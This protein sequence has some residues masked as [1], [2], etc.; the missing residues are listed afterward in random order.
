MPNGRGR[1]YKKE[2]YFRHTE[3]LP[4]HGDSNKLAQKSSDLAKTYKFSKIRV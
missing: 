2:L 3:K 1:C 4:F